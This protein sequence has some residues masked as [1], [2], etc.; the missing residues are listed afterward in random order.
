MAKNSTVT[1]V[2]STHLKRTLRSLSGICFAALLGFGCTNNKSDSA[3]VWIYTSLYK[4]TIADIQPKLEKQF[5]GVSFNFYQAGSEEVATKVNA[6]QMT[7]AI[8]ADLLISSDRFWYEDLARQGQLQA[9]KPIGTEAVP[10][11]FKNPASFYT[12]L[13]Y[14]VMVLA[15]NA[16]AVSEAEAPKSFKELTEAK[17][18]GKVSTGNPLSS[19]TNFTTLAF[20]Q[21]AYG[22]DYYRALRKNDLI[23]EGG[24]SGV[25]RRLQS[26][27]RPVGLVLLENILRLQESDPRIKTVMP[28][29][30]VVI[31]SNVLALVKKER[32]SEQKELLQ[33]IADWMFSKEGQEAMVRSYMYASMPGYPPPKNAPQLEEVL[34]KARPWTKDFLEET[35]QARESLKEEFSKIVF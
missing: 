30:G 16:D 26:K 9:Y 2:C 7:G 31:Q 15:Y 24:N 13:S 14:P 1:I 8:Q 3:K 12:T 5:P 18:K 21:K 35:L 19:G 25:I 33:K 20:L 29:D 17:W 10:E 23:A 34:K 28:T 11:F 32:T 6:E 4:D 22:W 27:E